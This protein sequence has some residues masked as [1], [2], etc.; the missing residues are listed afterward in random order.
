MLNGQPVDTTGLKLV[1]G[2]WT[3]TPEQIAAIVGKAHGA[4]LLPV[5]Q[6]F[7]SAGANVGY[8]AN[9]GLMRCATPLRRDRL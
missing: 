8:D 3:G 1:D 5:R 4:N 7:E 9:S 2:H 6:T